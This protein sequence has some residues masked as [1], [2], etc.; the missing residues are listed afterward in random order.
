MPVRR[1][2]IS[3]LHLWS[4]LTLAVFVLALILVVAQAGAALSARLGLPGLARDL[5]VATVADKLAGRAIPADVGASASEIVMAFDTATNSVDATRWAYDIIPF[6]SLEGLTAQGS[7]PRAVLF[8]P[9]TDQRS[10]VVAG[11]TDCAGAVFA[12]DRFEEDRANLLATLTH[13]LVHNQGGNFCNAPKGFEGNRSQWV[14]SH[15]TAATLEVLAGMCQYGDAWACR[16]FWGELSKGARR[17]VQANLMRNHVY[18]LYQLWRDVFLLDS[19]R[20]RHRMAKMDRMWEGNQ[21]ELLDIVEKYGELPWTTMML[22][23]ICENDLLDTGNAVMIDEIKNV[24]AV[25]GMP[26]D[27]SQVTLGPLGTALVCAGQ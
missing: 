27:D 13:E 2:P 14:E 22:P 9:N 6:F 5:V 17:S 18:F 16:G 26:W 1:K 21:D 8:V 4:S 19:S 23:G 24:R 3:I 11:H 25:L 15:T 10:F 20:E 7:Y 12:N